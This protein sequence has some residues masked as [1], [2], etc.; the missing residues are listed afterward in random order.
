M[1]YVLAIFLISLNAFAIPQLINYQGQLTSP[2]GTPLDTTVAI[3]FNIWPTPVGGSPDWTE[4]HAAIVV[5]DG[6]FHVSL[7]SVTTLL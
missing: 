1:K 6:L 4:A 7:G 2:T 3:T 5:T